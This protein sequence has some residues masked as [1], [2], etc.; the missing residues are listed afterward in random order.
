MK[1]VD[2]TRIWSVDILKDGKQHF[3]LIDMALGCRSAY[4]DPEK[5]GVANG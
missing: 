2:L 4:W 1:D 3:W 5:A